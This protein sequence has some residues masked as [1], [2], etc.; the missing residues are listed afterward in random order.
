MARSWPDVLVV[1]DTATLAQ[2]YLSFLA[3][4]QVRAT[5]VSTGRA[6]LE[7]IEAS[8]PAAIVLD[9]NLPDMNGLEILKELK[10]RAVPCEVVIIT[11]NASINLAV[12]AMREGAFD[13]IVKPCSADRLRV[14][15]RNALERRSLAS[16]VEALKDTFTRAAFCGFVGHSLAMQRVYRILQSAA[17][18]TATVFVTG[19]SG[20]GKELCAEA[21]HRLSK[22]AKGP[23]VAINC[24]AIPHELLESELFGHVKGAFTGATSDRQGAA[25]RADGGTLFL[26]EIGEMRSDFQA[27][28]LRFLQTGQVQRIGEDRP[29]AVD[30]RIVCATNRDPR[31]EVAA[32]RFRED[33]FYRLHVIPVEMPPLREREDDV[34]LLARHFLGRFAEMDGKHFDGLTPEAEEAFLRY[35][36][37][38]NVR[39]LQNVVRKIV[40]LGEGPRVALDQLPPELTGP[41]TAP[42]GETAPPGGTVAAAVRPAPPRDAAERVASIVPLES[43]IDRTISEAI[44][45]CDGSIPRAAA[46]LKV[47]PSTIYRRL[48]AKAA[49]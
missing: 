27:K 23:L 9:V 10:A 36:W 28:M 13:F 33:L 37:P 21:L 34:L 47:S 31:S 14:T 6:A 35:P 39:E 29:Q 40:V 26:D 44:A 18:S 25:L 17:P 4:E 8:P 19:E 43:V 15:V 45:A 11:S 48:Q 5:T 24:A 12:E 30:V 41:A 49:P 42:A 1:E 20:T 7:R 2:T 3:R 46:A 32:G 22:R 38:G 16:T